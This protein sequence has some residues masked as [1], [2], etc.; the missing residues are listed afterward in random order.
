MSTEEQND[1]DKEPD[2]DT[3]D[4]PDDQSETPTPYILNFSESIQVTVAHGINFRL[5]SCRPGLGHF[6]CKQPQPDEI[7]R[8][9]RKFRE[10]GTC[11]LAS[12]ALSRGL[13][14]SSRQTQFC[15]LGRQA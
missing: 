11:R 2:Y 9:R 14:R 8:L 13:L 1:S 12:S 10:S 5:S 15:N 4:N 6:G 7:V 3:G